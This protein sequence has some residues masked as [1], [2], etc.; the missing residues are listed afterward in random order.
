MISC[1]YHFS[2]KYE[3]MVNSFSVSSK[4]E[5]F[6]SLK[7][8]SSPKE[9]RWRSGQTHSIY[10]FSTRFECN[11]CSSPIVWSVVSN[12]SHS[13]RVW[14]MIFPTRFECSLWSSPLVWSVFSHH[15]G[16]FTVVLFSIEQNWPSM[17]W[18]TKNTFSTRFECR[19]T[20]SPLVSS[21]VS[22]LLHSFR[23]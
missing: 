11:L 10:I 21:V 15:H 12:L 9:T 4:W 7:E 6:D 8:P 17:Q 5:E 13:F 14:F 3:T 1:F 20:S 19:F 16:Y 22:H 2:T 23:V 18:W